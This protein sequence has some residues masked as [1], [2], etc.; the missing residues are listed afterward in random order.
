MYTVHNT[1]WRSLLFCLFIIPTIHWSVVHN[2]FQ[3]RRLFATVYTAASFNLAVFVLTM[4]TAHSYCYH[5]GAMYCSTGW[6]VGEWSHRQVNW[7]KRV[8]KP[9]WN[10][11]LWSQTTWGSLTPFDLFSCGRSCMVAQA[12]IRANGQTNEKKW[13][14]DPTWHLRKGLTNC[15][16]T[17]HL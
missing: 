3:H 11:E 13:I 4:S 1:Q 5:S 16:K 8:D 7:A 15:N 6:S 17:W 12:V 9:T 14:F 2:H 10:V